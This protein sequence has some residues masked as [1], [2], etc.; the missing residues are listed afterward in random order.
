MGKK[1][2]QLQTKSENAQKLNINTL[3]QDISAD[4]LFSR[5][6]SDPRK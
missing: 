4:M 5:L 3:K 1:L 2:I 6:T